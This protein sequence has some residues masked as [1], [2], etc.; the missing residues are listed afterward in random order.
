MSS[1]ASEASRLGRR[2]L[3]GDLASLA[4]LAFLIGDLA[5]AATPLRAEAARAALLASL[6]RSTDRR[7]LWRLVARGGGRSAG[8]ERMLLRVLERAP[9]WLRWTANAVLWGQGRAVADSRESL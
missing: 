6:R 8:E 7:W 9:A 3:R 1:A 2:S 4:W 5:E